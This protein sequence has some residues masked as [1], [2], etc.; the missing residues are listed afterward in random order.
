MIL[1]LSCQTVTSQKNN[2]PS[3]SAISS[4]INNDD[5]LVYCQYLENIHAYFKE[6]FQDILSIIAWVLDPFSNVDTAGSSQLEEE[7]IELTT[8]EE[9]KNKFKNALHEFWLQNLITQLYP[10]LWSTVQRFLI[11]FSS[12]YLSQRG[13]SAVTTL[14]TKKRNWLHITERGDLS[15]PHIETQM[16]QTMQFRVGYTVQEK[17]RITQY[18]RIF[19]RSSG[20]SCFVVR[21]QIA[22]N[23]IWTYK[24]LFLIGS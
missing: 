14:L 17:I 20:N 7:L 2:F 21:V 13:F 19:E 9:L 6:Q 1:L 8:N 5:L 16:M 24:E 3:L 10:G 4:N 18:E 23:I 15:K 22:N 12:S 11:S